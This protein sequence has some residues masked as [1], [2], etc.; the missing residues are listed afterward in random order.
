MRGYVVV[1]VYYIF[2]SWYARIYSSIIYYTIYFIH[3]MRGYI[4]YIVF[5]SW[6][7]RIYGSI[8]ILY[9]LFMVCEDIQ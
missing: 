5:N 6:Y 1:Y 2:Y 4:L 9:I 3:G 7:A 8:R